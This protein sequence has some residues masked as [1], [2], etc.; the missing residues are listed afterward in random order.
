M[1]PHEDIRKSIWYVYYKI[2]NDLVII[3]FHLYFRIYICIY[4]HKIIII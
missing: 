3:M 2:E 4:I 1:N